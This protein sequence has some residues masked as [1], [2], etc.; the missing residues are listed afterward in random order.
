MENAADYALTLTRRSMLKAA[1]AGTLLA[2]ALPVRARG[3]NGFAPEQSAL[4]TAYLRIEADGT[5]AIL[6][7]DA[8]LGQGILTTH[9][10]YIAD[11]MGADWSRLKVGFSGAGEIYTN[12]QKN[13]QATGRSMGATGYFDLLRRVGAAA[14]V[15]LVTAGAQKLGVPASECD[16]RDSKVVHAASDRALDFAELVEAASNV[17]VPDDPPLRDDADL[18]YIGRS[19]PR[20]DVPAMVRGEAEY[21]VDVQRPGMKVAA[22]RACP[23]FG[24]RVRSVER[25]AVIGMP[26]V[27]EVIALAD[28]VAVVADSWW[29]ASRAL[30]ELPVEFDE[31]DAADFESD[32]MMDTLVAQLAQPGEQ[33]LEAGRD[34]D[35]D[36]A[37]AAAGDRVL[38]AV[39]KAPYLAHATMEPMSCAALVENGR[40]EVWSGTQSPMQSR[41]AA[42]R[43]LGIDAADVTM[44]RTFSGG[45]FGR[46][47]QTD[48]VVQAV[49]IAREI[50]GVP[51]KLIWSREEDIRHDF[52]R[53]AYALRFR[54]ALD[55]DGGINA[56][57]LRVGG[58][59]ILEAMRPG[60]LGGRVDPT[61]IAGLNDHSYRMANSHVEWVPHPTPVPIGVWRAVSHSQNGFFLESIIDE[62]AHA[63]GVDPLEWRLRH[64]QDS[65]I[66]A[67]LEKLAEVSG[68]DG[69]LGDGRG[70]GVA[71]TD[72]YGS[73]V[74]QV[75]QVSVSAE[76]QLKL[77]RFY[78]VVDCGRA[79]HPD[80]IRAQ[81]EGG[82][83]Y[84]LTAMM[85]G[86]IDVRGGS[87][88]QQNFNDYRS[89]LLRHAPPV[90]T[91]II[92]SGHEM[93][94]VGEPGLP[95][96][97]PAVTNAIHAATGIRIRELPLERQGWRLA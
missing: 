85:H 59:S 31:G 83:L 42:A 91:H 13:L 61:V 6:T 63:A 51:V 4:Q 79:I 25:D 46:R 12:P 70:R 60:M 17:P 37:L 93:G 38:D 84:G 90:E 73:I 8:E 86:A 22:I 10:M 69:P 80:N 3:G 24:G 7:P 75:A 1:G 34:G 32:A 50:P 88:Q 28:A 65:R 21:A 27:Y 66:R 39:Y 92:E 53:P 56:L 20:Q 14:R 35:V 71:L 5:V 9:A 30:T 97:A 26:G 47:W 96:A 87:V 64:L 29:E 41:D 89:L 81:M 36:S 40:C 18:R 52:Y 2:F 49:S 44:H 67:V 11:E 33:V 77:E 62:I 82:I 72:S 58:A 23:V 95:P 94:G 68:W 45:G 55:D 57:H 43:A 76:R 48:F 74:A 54:A 16:T 19:M 78:C 15:Q